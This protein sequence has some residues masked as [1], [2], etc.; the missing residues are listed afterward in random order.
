[1]V[2]LFQGVAGMM[3]LLV[4]ASIDMVGKDVKNVLVCFICLNY[5][6]DVSVLAINRKLA[7]IT[8]FVQIGG[9]PGFH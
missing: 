8:F 5:E 6:K 1:M 2:G 4:R 7:G 3:Q 9:M